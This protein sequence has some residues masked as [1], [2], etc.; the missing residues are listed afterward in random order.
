MAQTEDLLQ[1]STVQF[2]SAESVKGQFM[3]AGGPVSEQGWPGRQ[4]IRFGLCQ[5]RRVR[6]LVFVAAGS[7]MDL[8]MGL[9]S[10]LRETNDQR[11]AAVIYLAEP[12]ELLLYDCEMDRMPRQIR[13]CR[14][15]RQYGQNWAGPQ[16]CLTEER[17]RTGCR[18]FTADAHVFLCGPDEMIEQVRPLLSEMGVKKRR[19]CFEITCDERVEA[20]AGQRMKA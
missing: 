9:L 7:G 20:N 3:P 10:Y 14:F 6:K 18:E 19:V 16:G 13:Y 15:A 12:S 4:S 5:R 8:V 2:Y 17:L 1:C 11:P